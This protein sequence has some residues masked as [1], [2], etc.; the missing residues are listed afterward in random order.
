MAR[1]GFDV[2]GSSI[3]A[4]IVD[5][6]ARI[7]AR[8][9]A[10]FPTGEG[11]DAIASILR[12]LAL[13]M[14]S[15]SGIGWD[16]IESIGV[17]VPGSIDRSGRIILNAHNLQLHDARLMDALENS[18][19]GIPLSIE[20]DAN[21]AALAE[22]CAGALRGCRTAVLLTLGTG[23]GGGLILNGRMYP[24]GMRNGVEIGHMIFNASGGRCTCGNRGCIESMCT[25]AYLIREGRK[26]LIEFPSCSIATLARG[27]FGAVDARLVIDCAREGDKIA[28]DIFERFLTALAGALSGL[29]AALDPEM[30]AIGGG[31]GEAGEYF[32]DELR[33]RLS[34]PGHAC[35]IVPARMGNSAGIIGAAMLLSEFGT[36][37]G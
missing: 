16:K 29:I 23:V 9:S 14:T 11:V 20:N 37:I 31:V 21:A 13:E 28:L 34:V 4:G 18:F 15:Q 36:T 6:D 24:G 35:I 5:G 25:A 19:P 33:S 17:A 30:L 32:F 10:A 7:L 2:G 26:A 22:L 3:K 8:A 1:I 12:D 27:E